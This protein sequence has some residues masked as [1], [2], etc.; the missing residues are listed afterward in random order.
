MKSKLRELYKRIHPDLFHQHP[1]AQAENSRSF[2]LLQEYLDA[3]L[4]G[5]G[6]RGG[7]LLPYRFVF[8]L[9][10]DSACEVDQVRLV[11]EDC[12]YEECTKGCASA[13]YKC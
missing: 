6:E 2:Q 3:A 10:N 11:V 8:Y 5:G 1:E 9:H 12:M 7:V 13:A 4:Q